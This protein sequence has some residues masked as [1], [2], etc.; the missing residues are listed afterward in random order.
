MTRDA[1]AELEADFEAVFSAI[2]NELSFAAVWSDD[3]IQRDLAV[4]RTAFLDLVR[5]SSL[6]THTRYRILAN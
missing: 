1:I 5:R 2:P 3:E 4:T 6:G